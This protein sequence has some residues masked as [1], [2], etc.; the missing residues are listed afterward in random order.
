MSEPLA[1]GPSLEQVRAQIGRRFPGGTYTIEPWRAWLISDA[2]L[3]PPPDGK[4]AHPLFAWLAATGGWG[5]TWDDLFGW[6]GA[7][8]AD[9]PMFGEHETTIHRSLTIGATY[10][11]TGG[12]TS[13]DRKTG[14]TTGP[15][16]VVGYRM[17][18]HDEADGVHVA[19]CWN[20]IIFPRRE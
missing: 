5:M 1:A 7:G 8:A 19:T 14:R 2:V 13:A 20:S 17:D 18:L 12:I 9:G 16:D 10:R 3:E 6:F 15:F 4:L 11:V